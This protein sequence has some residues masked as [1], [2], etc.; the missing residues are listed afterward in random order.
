M[1]PSSAQNL[2]RASMLVLQ[3]ALVE[4]TTVHDAL[5]RLHCAQSDAR[6][7]PQHRVVLF[8][9]NDIRETNREQCL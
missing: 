5:R 1:A 4:S 3:S 2:S 7:F 6:R 9:E 8:P